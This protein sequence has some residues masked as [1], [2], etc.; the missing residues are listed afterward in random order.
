VIL[1]LLQGFDAFETERVN[2]VLSGRRIGIPVEE[3]EARVTGNSDF[4]EQLKSEEKKLRSRKEF[5]EEALEDA[6]KDHLNQLRYKNVKSS[7]KKTVKESI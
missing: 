5:F 3:D 6:R 1:L 2:R 4:E 7:R